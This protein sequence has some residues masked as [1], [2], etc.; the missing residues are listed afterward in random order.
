MRPISPRL[1]GYEEIRIAEDQHEYMPLQAAVMRDE[2]GVTGLITRW[3]MTAEERAAVAA[4]ADVYVAQLTFGAPMQ[5]MQ[6][7]VK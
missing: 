7:E 3:R 4:G 1:D 2:G 6:L 5:P